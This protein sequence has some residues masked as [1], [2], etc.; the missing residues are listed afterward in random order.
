MLY[1]HPTNVSTAGPANVCPV[2]A[3]YYETMCQNSGPVHPDQRR[4]FVELGRRVARPRS[5]DRERPAMSRI[6]RHRAK[7]TER[8]GAAGARLAGL[9][10]RHPA[11]VP[12]D[13]LA[14]AKALAAAHPDG[15]VDLSVGTPVDPVAPVIREALA[16]ASSASVIPPRL[17]PP[18]CASPRWPP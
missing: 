11:G 8:P 14:D 2:E 1:I 12:W 18:G 4:L 9:P 5:A 6:W 13:T 16:A 7:A 3:I 17:G 15:I 10:W